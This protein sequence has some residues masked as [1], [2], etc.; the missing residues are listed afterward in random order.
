MG[1][2]L[3]PQARGD[4][5]T[6]W[7]EPH[8]MLAVLTRFEQAYPERAGLAR[9]LRELLYRPEVLEGPL[10]NVALCSATLQRTFQVE[11]YSFA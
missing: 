4:V 11:V 5:P 10:P 7:P 9:S 6:A 3:A 8:A 2:E 1:H